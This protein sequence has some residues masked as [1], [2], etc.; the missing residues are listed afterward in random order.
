MT[1]NRTLTLSYDADAGQVLLEDLPAGPAGEAG[2]IPAEGIELLFDCADGR[3]SRVF[4]EA[5]EPGGPPAT[6][7]PAMTA[8]ARLLG[9]QA[10]AAIQHAA[11]KDGDPVAVAAEP[12]TIVALSRLARL[13]AARMISPVPESFRWAVEAAPL[14]ARAGLDAR[15]QAEAR[16]AGDALEGADDAS[17]ATLAPVA[18]I[19]ADL[20]QDAEPELA[21]RLRD[22]A[23]ES[24]GGSGGA[25]TARARSQDRPELAAEDGQRGGVTGGL[26][27][28]LDPRLIPPGVFRHAGWPG[29]ELTVRAEQ[30]GIVIEA[31][32]APGADRQALGQCRARLV[33]PANR[34]VLGAAPFRDLG[35]SRVRAE[36]HER[37]P[38]R[39]AWVEVV[40]DESRPVLSGQLHRM[41]RAMRWADAALSASRHASGVADAEWARLAAVAW[42]RC[43]EDWAAADDPDR[44]YLAAVRRA[45][46]CPGVAV[47]PAPSGWAKEL[48]S[49][50]ALAEEPFLAERVDC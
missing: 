7:E 9:P 11:S 29:A 6:D 5:G 43:A 14:A 50:P 4:I 24:P 12:G 32:L 31:E 26:Q 39:E 45:A 47:P 19:V 33:D 25:R 18:S 1:N 13:D 28:W 41:R 2:L 10:R 37:V 8:V 30:Y 42:G 35:N 21:K 34:S 16:R 46:I 20:V 3:L 36:I 23:A 15:V 38:P 40:D 27:W 49:R 44:A 17:L 48:A 22:H